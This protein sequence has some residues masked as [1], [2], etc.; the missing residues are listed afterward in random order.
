MVDNSE[1]F[2]SSAGIW[3]PGSVGHYAPEVFVPAWMCFRLLPAEQTLAK[4]LLF[5]QFLVTSPRIPR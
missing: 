4:A 3:M 2:L 1:A 5:D